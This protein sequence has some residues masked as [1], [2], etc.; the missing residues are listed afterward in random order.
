MGSC[1]LCS[2]LCAV[3]P[4][5]G[6]LDSSQ[7]LSLSPGLSFDGFLPGLVALLGHFVRMSFWV[8]VLFPETEFPPVPGSPPLGWEA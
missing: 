6:F 2:I 4:E 5:L 7:W 8:R 1:V 3:I